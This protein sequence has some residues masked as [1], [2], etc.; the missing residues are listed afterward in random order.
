MSI[1]M[2][3]VVIAGVSAGIG[4]IVGAAI[5][6]AGNQILCKEGVQY[7]SYI[8]PDGT[9]KTY[10]KIDAIAPRDIDKIRNMC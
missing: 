9:Y 2:R 5:Y 8:K 7:T 10:G 6:E 3:D 4:L 1:K